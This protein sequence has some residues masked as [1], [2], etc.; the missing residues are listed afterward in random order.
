MQYIILWLLILCLTFSPFSGLSVGVMNFMSSTTNNEPEVEPEPVIQPT[1]APVEEPQGRKITLN[2]TLDLDG[3]CTIMIP[4]EYWTL[5]QE[6]STFTKK[7]TKYKDKKS[8]IIMSYLVNISDDA[9]IPGYITRES[10]GLDIVTN[11][12]H[13]VEYKSGTW[14]VIPAEEVIDGCYCTVYYITSKDESTAFWMRVNRHE[15]TDAEEF[16]EVITAIIDSYNMYY[17]GGTVFDTPTGGYYAEHGADDQGIVSD[18]TD[19]KKNTQENNVWDSD[20][21]GFDF[22]A[23]ISLRWDSMEIIVDDHKLTLP[24]TLK[25]MEEADFKPNDPNVKYDTYFIDAGKSKDILFSNSKGTIVTMTFLN[26]SNKDLKDISECAAVKIDI[27]TSSFVAVANKDVDETNENNEET[28]E[29]NG[30]EQTTD[31]Q[32]TDE[33]TKENNEQAEEN[34]QTDETGE[35]TGEESGE[36]TEEESE[37]ENTDPVSV[38]QGEKEFDSITHSIILPKGIMLNVYTQDIIDSYGEP[39]D[40]YRS[41]SQLIYTWKKDGKYMRLECGAVKNIKHITISTME[42]K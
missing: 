11:S 40:R 3:Y 5:N 42:N 7:I 20:Q 36:Q 41:E 34:E 32:T 27:D 14:T 39:N 29:E 6:D 30:E 1:E 24:C 22:T 8:K 37:E 16:E 33:Q 18:T 19:Y 21:Q 26:D 9:D 2:N 10:A 17:I 12:K 23:D 31:E 38:M 28:N 4:S 15:D 25:D 13:D 35:Q